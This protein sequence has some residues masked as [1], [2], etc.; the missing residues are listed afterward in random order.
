MKPQIQESS[1]WRQTFMKFLSVYPLSERDERL[2]YAVLQFLRF[3]I[4]K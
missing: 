2:L 1:L 3:V 4:G